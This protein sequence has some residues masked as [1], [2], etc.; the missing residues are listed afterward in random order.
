MAKARAV[1]PQAAPSRRTTWQISRPGPA[2]AELDRDQG[3]E[4]ALAFSKA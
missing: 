1:E 4:E 2:A 3:L